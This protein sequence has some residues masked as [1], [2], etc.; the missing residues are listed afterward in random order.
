M[1]TLLKWFV[2]C[3]VSRAAVK[4]AIHAANAELAKRTASDRGKTVINAVNDVSEVGAA[5]LKAFADGE[6][7]SAEL[8]AA[9][10]AVDTALDKYLTDELIDRAIDAL[11]N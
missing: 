1:K 5:Y 8:A 2:K 6:M 11:F 9:N 3:V 7:D 4:N 10:A